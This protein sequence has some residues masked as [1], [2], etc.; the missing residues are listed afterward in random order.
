MELF[1]S[2]ARGWQLL[3]YRRTGKAIGVGKYVVIWKQQAGQ[4]KIH[5][6]IWT[7]ALTTPA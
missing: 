2:T 5:C 3:L 6:D 7:S 4:W 1:H